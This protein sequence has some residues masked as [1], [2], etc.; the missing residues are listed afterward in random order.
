M[1]VE[2]AVTMPTLKASTFTHLTLTIFIEVRD[3]E[4]QITHCFKI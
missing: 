4:L 3:F 2:T 1:D